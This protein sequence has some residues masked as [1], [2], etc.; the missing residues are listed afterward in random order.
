MSC[1]AD[2]IMPPDGDRVSSARYDDD[3]W[4][5]SCDLGDG[6]RRIEFSVPDIHCGGCIQKIEQGLGELDGVEACRVN[7]TERRVSIT[8]RADPNATPP[9]LHRLKRLGFPAHIRESDD[10]VP[11]KVR[12]QL[13]RSLAVAGFASG[14]IMLLSVSVWAGADAPLR[15]LFH[16]LSAAIALPVLIYSGR[17]FFK[18]AWQAIRQGHTNM[19]VPISV[20]VLLAYALSI[21]DTLTHREDVYF[22]ASVT[23][24]FVLLIGRTLDHLMREKARSALGGLA[25]LNPRGARVLQE[26]GSS[27]SVSLEEIRP[28]MR[29]LL[30]AGE[31]VPVDS[32][33]LSG[34]S[35]IDR[36][37]VTGESEPQSAVIGTQLQAGTLNLTAPLVIQ[38]TA[39]AAESFLS[40][41]LRLVEAAEAERP[42]YRRIIDRVSAIYAPVVH[43]T[44]LLSFIGWFAIDGDLHNA[45]TVAIAVLIITCPCALGLAVPIVQVVA[46]RQLF[47][48]GIIVKD[49]AVLERLHQVDVVLFDK[50]GTLTSGQP[51]LQN[52]TAIST[53]NARLAGSLA[54]HSHHPYSAA[55]VAAYPHSA[56]Q[57]GE[58]DEIRDRPGLGVEA[59]SGTN[60]FR[61]GRIGW[62]APAREVAGSLFHDGPCCVLSRDEEMLEVFLFE[63]PIRNGAKRAVAELRQAGAAIEIISGDNPEAVVKVAG[64]LQIPNFRAGVMPA[65]KVERVAGLTAEGHK[66]L[67]VGDGL[68][69]APAFGAAYVS[70]AP[71]NAADIGR[72]A[73]DI[74]FL[75]ES[76]EAVPRAIAI[77]RRAASLVH[78]NLVS[79]ILYNTIALPL[80]VAGQVTPLIAALAMS[81]SSIA[82]VFNSLRLKYRGGGGDRTW[83]IENVPGGQK[84]ASAT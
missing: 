66:V 55:I 64:A 53:S 63:D 14:N 59:R 22:D 2:T 50:T 9:F 4:S 45:L 25:R 79:A 75:G 44:A 36:S 38:A 40:E 65:E 80:A 3:V 7:L 35:D 17:V 10:A 73:A 16:W 28:G 84:L 54:M 47:E 42:Y 21:Y 27:A 15:D 5:S 11:D 33:V 6:L 72:N 39:V 61:L 56:Y 76:L 43:C 20:G 24:L 41:M 49:G 62:S 57:K 37:L 1:V 34:E 82:V 23:L 68:N 19:D 78:Q 74:I 30:S 29:I 77:S 18:S 12:S 69:D 13:I 70:M 58:F 8:W 31:R 67:M 48:R 32:A 60:T 26:G 81:S 46:A 71:S 52:Q 83:G 51:R